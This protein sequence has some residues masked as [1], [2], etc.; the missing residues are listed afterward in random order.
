MNEMT[1]SAEN[2]TEKLSLNLGIVGGG[3]TCKYFLELLK[4]ESL[5]YLDIHLVGVCDTNPNAEGF[6]LARE[7]GIYTTA[8]FRDLFRIDGLDGIIELTNSRDVLLQLIRYR[9]KRVAVIEHNIGRF[10]RN[11]FVINQRL[12]AAEQQVMMEKMISDFLIQ[13]AKQRIVALNTDFTVAEAN[14]AY[15][16]AIDKPREAVV[17]AYCY[18]IIR[19]KGGP[20]VDSELHFKCPMMETLRTGESAHVIHEDPIAKDR[21]AYIDIVTYPVKDADG[22]IIRIIEV[23]RDITEEIS[24]RM[25]ERVEALKSDLNKLVQ[26]DRLISLGKLVASCV[27]EINNPIQGLLTFS[28]LIQEILS[29]GP[30]TG[31]VLEKLEQFVS[32]MSDE[33]DR[34]GNIVSGLLS[35]SRESPME[36]KDLDLNEVMGTVIT[37][38]Q[39][40]MELQEIQLT[41]D[42][43]PERLIIHG[44]GNRLQQCFLNLVFN[45]IEAMP[46]GG[47]LTIASRRDARE[48]NAVMEIRDTG[49]GIPPGNLDHI[50]DP[51]FTTKNSGE[52]TGL[53]LSIVYG[54]VK[55]HKGKIQVNSPQGRGT[56]FLLRFPLKN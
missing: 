1:T 47:E 26:E 38:T 12:K 43:S 50:F 30:P 37:L 14:D 10:I 45:A 11:F 20:C 15:L 28:H 39:H 21:L 8:D 41:T 51:F 36:Y 32:I 42:L 44:D 48:K 54:V 55:S 22:R 6:R 4:Q 19:G 52:G 24:S 17:G 34:C 56:S 13:Q 5:P 23:W 7:M 31:E 35:F 18:Q 27:H 9:P 33:L 49:Y 25:E 29:E 3:R 16:A 46:S 53:G 40:R 2:S